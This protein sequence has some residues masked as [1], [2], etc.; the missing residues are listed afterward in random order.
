M[1]FRVFFHAP[2]HLTEGRRDDW[3]RIMTRITIMTMTITLILII[4]MIIIITKLLRCQ[5]M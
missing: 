5:T 1:S 4:I 3:E 2:L